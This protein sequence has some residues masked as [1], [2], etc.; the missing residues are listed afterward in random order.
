MYIPDRM[1]IAKMTE[2]DSGE[3]FTVVACLR[4]CK[5]LRA[6]SILGSRIEIYQLI[7]DESKFLFLLY[8]TERKL[9]IEFQ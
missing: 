5:R 9:H 2:C 3:L 6:E 8:D 4:I 7:F 1:A